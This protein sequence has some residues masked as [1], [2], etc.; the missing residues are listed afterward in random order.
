M[1]VTD[2]TPNFAGVLHIRPGVCARGDEIDA[3]MA[4][5]GL[6]AERVGDVY[7]GLATLG[8]AAHVHTV[9]VSVDVL[10]GLEFEFFALASRIRP[11]VHLLVYGRAGSEAKMEQALLSG[12]SARATV[13]GLRTL[14]ARLAEVRGAAPGDDAPGAK[15]ESGRAETESSVDEPPSLAR[16]TVVESGEA[17]TTESSL[18]DHSESALEGL[19]ALDVSERAGASGAIDEIADEIE[20][21]ADGESSSPVR[22]PWA[23][24]LAPDRRQGPP[25]TPPSRD[26]HLPPRLH[27]VPLPREIDETPAGSSEERETLLTPEELSALL[28]DE[29][30]ALEPRE[31]RREGGAP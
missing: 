29:Y 21:D 5:A 18:S 24:P 6:T 9:V 23:R 26:G 20:G 12:A 22:F 19:K 4:E 16:A 31:P 11:G 8:R 15:S 28:G 2:T 27:P 10:D 14:A 13:F 7:R 25:R 1:A 17:R 30:T 3:W